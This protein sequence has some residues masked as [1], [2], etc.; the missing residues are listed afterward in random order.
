MLIDTIMSRMHQLSENQH[1]LY[2]L[3]VNTNRDYMSI[4]VPSSKVRTLFNEFRKR[5]KDMMVI[6]RIQLA[7]SLY[8]QGYEEL[9]IFANAI[10]S[11][12]K[13]GLIPMHVG[14]LDTMPNFFRGWYVTDDFTINILQP[15]LTFNPDQILELCGKWHNSEITWKR[16]AS[17]V[18][19]VRKIGFSG[20]FLD[21]LLEIV[22]KFYK[23]PEPMVQKALGWAIKDNLPKGKK[24]LLPIL[25][26]LHE[27]GADSSMMRI[28]IKGL[29]AEEKRCI[30]GG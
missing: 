22:P 28:A 20:L 18:L 16:R 24:R 27:S 12:D 19:F 9:G 17:A 10:L 30:Y 25:R 4:G 23:D 5:I 3:R 8:K 2:N 1:S 21:Q 15:L 13:R 7:E 11:L 14:Y 6:D 26:E 29:S